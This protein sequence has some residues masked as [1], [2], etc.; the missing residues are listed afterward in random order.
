MNIRRIFSKIKRILGFQGEYI[1]YFKMLGVRFT[2]NADVDKSVIFGS[3]PYLITIGNNTRITRGVQFIT[4]DG[5]LWTLKQMGLLDMS[6]VKYG[7]IVVGDNC[8]IGWNAII[9]PNVSIGNNCIIAAGAVV[10][11]DVPE[12]TIVGGIPAEY[13]E[14][15]EEYYRKV[16]NVTL[17]TFYA[18]PEEKRRI[19][20]K[21]RPEWFRI[22]KQN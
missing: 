15:V 11:K 13:I 1:K 4:H 22:K 6:E 2:G 17:P 16:K 18:T 19:L 3:E 5:G 14:T 10:T 20:E 9:M 7:P 8:N 21:E 12:G